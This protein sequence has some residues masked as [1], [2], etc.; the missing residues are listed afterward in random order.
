[1]SIPSSIKVEEIQLHTYG[2]ACSLASLSMVHI[3]NR[4]FYNLFLSSLTVRSKD[5][6]REDMG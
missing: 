5:H 4:I 2:F 1:M 6:G 3:H